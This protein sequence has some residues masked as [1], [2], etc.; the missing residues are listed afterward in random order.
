M[1]TY[2][3]RIPYSRLIAPSGAG[4][5]EAG[6]ERRGTG[7]EVDNGAR[8]LLDLRMSADRADHYPSSSN[9]RARKG[10]GL[11]QREVA[12]LLTRR[13]APGHIGERRFRDLERL[14]A[15]WPP[16]VADAYAD[17][18]GL[19]EPGRSR[20][21]A[22]VGVVPAYGGDTVLEA[23]LHH[24]NVTLGRS[25]AY[26]ADGLWDLRARNE[27][28]KE[29]VP[30]LEPGMNIMDFILRSER[31]RAIFPDFEAW[32]TPM[33][34]HL[35]TALL[36]ARNPGY[37]AG[38]ELLLEDLLS[39]ERIAAA[40]KECQRIGFDPIGDRRS[41]RPPD[42][43]TPDGLGE[44]IDVELYRTT[45]PGKP[46][47]WRVMCVTRCDRPEEPGRAADPDPE[48]WWRK[49]PRSAEQG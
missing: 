25:P 44:P 8:F 41:L 6:I 39:D 35:Y 45:P 3:H 2:P 16:Y 33:L 18:L 10:K 1:S 37:K 5:A 17:L 23:D 38:L 29:L 27:A 14:N 36:Q 43:C 19:E 24:L 34:A 11:K 47:G 49:G 7:G 4:G 28:L 40:W 12:E 21:Y 46:E 22:V 15:R 9:G 42:P 31:G 32:A 26:I 13:L 48:F 20:F 30:E